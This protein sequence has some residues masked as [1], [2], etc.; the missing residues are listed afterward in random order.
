L[1]RELLAQ[2][3]SRFLEI[4]LVY[5]VIPVKEFSGLIPGYLHCD[6]FRDSGPYHVS[7]RGSPKV[8]GNLIRY[9][10]VLASPMPRLV[11][12]KNPLSL[13]VEHP[14]AL[15][16]VREMFLSLGLYWFLQ[17]TRKV[18]KAAVFIL[19]GPRL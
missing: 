3:A 11:E 1:G 15:G 12:G 6:P 7:D 14:R 5:N 17:H 16:I 2:F 4:H 9:A 19:G 8:V 10:G 13:V 18:K